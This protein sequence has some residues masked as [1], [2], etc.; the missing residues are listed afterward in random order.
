MLQ[1]ILGTGQLFFIL[2]G[3]F[4]VFVLCC[5]I[6]FVAKK[7]FI[8][9]VQLSVSYNRVSQC[10]VS[11]PSSSQK[12]IVFGN[13]IFFHILRISSFAW[14]MVVSQCCVLWVH[15]I[16]RKWRSTWIKLTFCVRERNWEEKKNTARNTHTHTPSLSRASE[17]K[18][19][20][21]YTHCQ[22]ELLRSKFVKN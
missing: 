19:S 11:A 7:M 14:R 10:F 8:F 9:T 6:F 2:I 22:V 20:Q 4:I 16:V 3:F 12:I 1:P 17:T 21:S 15:T 13:F 5:K 18:S